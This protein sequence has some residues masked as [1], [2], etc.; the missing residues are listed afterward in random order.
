M[1]NNLIAPAK[2]GDWITTQLKITGR[3]AAHLSGFFTSVARLYLPV[4][5]G[6][7]GPSSDGSALRDADCG[8]P[9]NPA[10]QISKLPLRCGGLKD[11]SR[12]LTM[13][14]LRLLVDDRLSVYAKR[15]RN[16]IKY[17]LPVFGDSPRILLDEQEISRLAK[18]PIEK[19]RHAIK[20]L[21]REGYL[22]PFF[23]GRRSKCNVI[24]LLNPSLSG[25]AMEVWA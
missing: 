14:Q 11:K 24:A 15:V 4:M 8:N 13:A 25:D 10:T 12:R 23:H 6:L 5:V 9:A 17:H 1:S 18:I 2:S 3:Q 20:E 21:M 19:V 7:A 22:A 16:A